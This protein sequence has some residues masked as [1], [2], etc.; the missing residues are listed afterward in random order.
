MLSTSW[1]A[2]TSAL[3]EAAMLCAAT[4]RPTADFLNLYEAKL[5]SVEGPPAAD[6]DRLVS[7]DRQ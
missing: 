6:G 4:L 3:H 5:R 1:H 7:R 2:L